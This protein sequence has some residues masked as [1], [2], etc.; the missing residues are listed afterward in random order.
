M[1]DLLEVA[2]DLLKKIESLGY[3]AYIVGGTPRDILRGIEPYDIDI[4]TNCP[5][6]TL[7]KHFTAYSI[8]ISKDF[9]IV[10]IKYKGYVYEVAQFRIES[11]YDGVR[12][13]KIVIID[14]LEEDV[15]RRDFTIN[16]I[17]MRSDG[18]MLDY[19]NGI[20][21]INNKLIRAVGDPIERFTEDYVRMIRAARFCAMDGFKLEPATR[22][23]IQ[24]MSG[25]VIKITPE[26]VRLELI[27][28]ADKQGIKFS[29]FILL[30]DELNLLEYLLPEIH[31]LKK[32]NHDVKYHPKG[33]TVFDHIIKC[34]E[35]ANNMNYI[36]KLA[37]L[38]HDIGKLTTATTDREGKVHYYG[39]ASAGVHIA[40][41]ILRRYKFKSWEIN[42][43]L[44]AVKN[45]MKF[46]NI[47]NM[48]PFKV[49]NILTNPYF[50]VLKDVCWADEY[51]RGESFSHYVDFEHKIQKINEIEYSWKNKN[52]N[53]TN[54]ISGNLIM[55][56]LNIK[57]G[58]KVGKIKKEVEAYII[59]NS[60]EP[61]DKLIKEL[62]LKHLNVGE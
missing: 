5:I 37:I 60:L 53:T 43:I 62:I 44:Y 42:N 19:L 47:L 13:G 8:G 38:F 49:I 50:D 11:N 20:E 35:I 16:S 14:S 41:T 27:K 12:P 34:L 25:S 22:K 58:P 55:S 39:H 30:L 51:S 52:T 56:L 17:A 29:K 15:K 57:P 23:A 61:T 21:D 33:P 45:H 54:F 3:E 31:G 9:G 1:N 2:I 7:D 26:R 4:T 24:K 46:H 10:V 28:A 18:S 36:S 59:D 40:S 48:R 6:D 32:L